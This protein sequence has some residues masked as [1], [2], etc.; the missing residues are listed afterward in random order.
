MRWRAMMLPRRRASI[1]GK[2]SKSGETMGVISTVSAGRPRASMS[3]SA[4]LRLLAEESRQGMRMANT[5]AGPSARAESAAASAESMPP[6]RA[7]T[8]RGRPAFCVWSRMKPQM[9]SVASRVSIAR[10]ARP[11]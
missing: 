8:A 6:D 9:M 11:C 1:S 3:R 2:R 7:I 5:F 10:R 4:S